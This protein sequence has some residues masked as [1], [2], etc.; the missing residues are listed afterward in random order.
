ML[1]KAS[2]MKC[3]KMIFAGARLSALI[4]LFFTMTPLAFGYQS[5]EGYI[6]EPV[7][8]PFTKE[9]EDQYIRS[10]ANITPGSKILSKYSSKE[11]YQAL[12]QRMLEI[13]PAPSEIEAA[14]KSV[15]RYRHLAKSKPQQYLPALAKSLDNLANVLFANMQDDEALKVDQE[16]IAVYRVLAQ[17]NPK[18]FEFILVVRLHD[19]AVRWDFTQR[20]FESIKFLQE[21]V[22]VL[23]KMARSDMEVY[24][25]ALGILLSRLSSY[26]SEAELYD[27]AIQASQEAVNIKRAL[28]QGKPIYLKGLAEDLDQLAN[29]YSKVH[30]PDEAIKAFREAVNVY[31]LILPQNQEKYLSN[32]A[33]DLKKI[34]H[35]LF[36][37]KRNREVLK[38]ARELVWVCQESIKLK[39]RTNVILILSGIKDLTK[40]MEEAGMKQE[41]SEFEKLI[42][43]IEQNKLPPPAPFDHG[44]ELLLKAIFEYEAKKYSQASKTAQEAISILRNFAPHDILA[45]SFLVQARIVLGSAQLALNKP[46]KAVHVFAQGLRE[47]FQPLWTMPKSTVPLAQELLDGYLKACRQ[48]GQP[49]NKDLIAPIQA[50]L[51]KYPSSQEKKP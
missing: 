47:V 26:L 18:K 22:D 20:K 51:E 14:R 16:A 6:K 32:I 41:A 5:R 36:N 35:H 46:E 27:K 45:T 39:S 21:S 44:E 8:A 12:F 28:A 33:Q 3:T 43:E 7:S 24:Q 25:S 23:R 10:I 34:A 17:R 48:I 30:K 13:K 50:I 2:M 49:P 29:I 9:K 40:R 11:H 15:A 38:V 4:S 37:L 31:R 1:F 19:K 42:K